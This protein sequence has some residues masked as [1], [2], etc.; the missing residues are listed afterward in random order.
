[1]ESLYEKYWKDFETAFWEMEMNVGRIRTPRSSLFLNHWLV[2]RTGEEVVAREVFDRFKRYA[3]HDSGQPMTALIEHLSR[4]SKVYRG[5]VEAAGVRTGSIERLALF[6]YRTGVLESE[7]IKPLVLCM[8]D[9][10]EPAIPEAQI[11]KALGVVE[12]WMVRRML[13]RA[14]TKA[15]NQIVAE[16]IAVIRGTGRSAAGDTIE[17]FL[18]S[19]NVTHRY[20]PDD[21]ELTSELTAL[22]AYRRIGR[23]RLRMVLEAVEDHLRG[24]RA[25]QPAIG[26][27]RVARS[28]LAIEHVMPRKWQSHWPLASE[29]HNEEE[30]DKLIHMLGNLTLLTGRLNSRVSNGP[31][32]GEG[33]KRSGLE[34]N[35]VLFLNRDVL[36]R[37]AQS[38][39]EAQIA[40]RTHDVVANIVDI[41]PVP[42]G[43]KSGFATERAPVRRRFLKIADLI[44]AGALRAGTVL[45]PR[46]KQYVSR[47]ATILPDGRIELEGESYESPSLAA[48]QLVGRAMNG[49]WFFLVEVSPRKS[50]AVV[51]REYLDSLYEDDDD[52][53][54]SDAEDEE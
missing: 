32:H 39:N 18:A 13:V 28:T 14:T 52:D 7:V 9:P 6:G 24:W 45:V 53:D 11:A 2:A 12:S 23:G 3:L 35:D 25:G 31:W 47:T 27:E 48:E 10:Q 42:L 43:H 44:A 15:Y 19:Q 1:V 36:R 21:A 17:K 33:G 46:R 29:G 54:E 16:M 51:R 50:L 38:W 22:Q 20:W 8:L 40:A 34:G 5:F 37:G 4:A 26:G 49:W 30:R 41:W